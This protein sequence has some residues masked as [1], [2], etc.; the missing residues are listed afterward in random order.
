MNPLLS[1]IKTMFYNSMIWALLGALFA[2]LFVLLNW[3]SKR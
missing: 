3:R 1:N 2:T